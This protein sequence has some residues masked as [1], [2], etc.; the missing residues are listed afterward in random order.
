[1]Y[2]KGMTFSLSEGKSR[3]SGVRCEVVALFAD[4]RLFS[5]WSI[6]APLD[7]VAEV[8]KVQYERMIQISN[9]QHPAFHKMLGDGFLLLWEEDSEMDATLCLQ[10]ALD[11]AFELHKKYWHFACALSY[12]VPPGFG[13]GISV[14]QAIKVEPE[15]FLAE[16]NEVDFLGYPLNCAARMQALA[17]AFEIAVCSTT[18]QRISRRPADL[19]CQDPA[20]QRELRDPSKLECERARNMRGLN[21]GDQTGFGYLSWP[22]VQR[23]LWGASCAT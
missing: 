15:T 20:F 9:D 22:A 4:L 18:R 6:R 5:D 3:F 13:V 1:M 2:T 16:L 21:T 12:E 7:Q 19:L 8:M 14:G 11:A 17:G 23:K 10:L